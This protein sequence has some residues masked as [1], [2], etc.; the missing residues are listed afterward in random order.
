MLNLYAVIIKLEL[1]ILKAYSV[2][3]FRGPDENGN[4]DT[5]FG[6][7]VDGEYLPNTTYQ[8]DLFE[9]DLLIPKE[10]IV[11]YYNFSFPGGEHVFKKILGDNKEIVNSSYVKHRDAVDGTETTLWRNN[12]VRY[13][14]S[15][16]FDDKKAREIRSAMNH[17]EANT[18]LR[19]IPLDREGEDHIEFIRTK[20]SCYS[21]YIGRLGGRQIINLPR[22]C[23]FGLIVHEIGHA[24]GF[25]HEQS[26]PDRDEYVTLH[27]DNMAKMSFNFIKQD[28]M[29]IDYQGSVYDYGSVMHYPRNWGSKKGCHG[30]SCFT[31]TVKNHTEYKRQGSPK[32]G[33]F[34]RLSKEDIIQANRLY[35]C[36]N[37][38][39][40]GFLLIQVKLGVN[41]TS[42]VGKKTNLYILVRAV[43]SK[44]KPHFEQT[45]LKRSTTNPIWNEMLFFGERNWQFFRIRLWNYDK[46]NDEFLSM[47][48]TV[49]VLSGHHEDIK[50]CENSICKGFVMFDYTLHARVSTKASLRVHVRS[51]VNLADTDPLWNKPDPY[52]LVEGL[53]SNTTMGTRTTS[54]IYDT[55]NPEWEE[56][57]DL[58]CSKW[59]SFFIQMM[60]EDVGL[61]DMLSNREWITLY[62]GFHSHNHHNGF[63]RGQ[64]SYDYDLKSCT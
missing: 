42:V 33:H 19:F 60:D 51:A 24:L 20:G 59:N 36:P 62:P 27:Y 8:K 57:L 6:E 4:S 46:T 52:V 43:D 28:D 44:G 38:G 39:V 5:F 49:P 35:S 17:W 55:V 34:S 18:C 37:D 7:T 23:A 61:D 64:L 21:N 16:V 45:A 26:R 56:W 13:I 3:T 14:I 50:H 58:G 30:R 25:W 1:V 32:I 2:R 53:R 12:T 41:L 47:S 11:S 22:H 15:S 54:T 31:L 10:L 63:N 48:Q 40:V 29:K 9:G